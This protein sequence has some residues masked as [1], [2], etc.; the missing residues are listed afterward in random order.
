MG[1][2]QWVG[3]R[4]E[5]LV[6]CRMVRMFSLNLRTYQNCAERS[7]Q[8]RFTYFNIKKGISWIII[9]KHII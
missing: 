8:V 3:V 7:I 1:E 4:D 9:H 2:V 6:W 5:L